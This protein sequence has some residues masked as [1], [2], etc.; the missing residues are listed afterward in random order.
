VRALRLGLPRAS[1]NGAADGPEIQPADLSAAPTPSYSSAYAAVAIPAD[2]ES[3]N[4][5]FWYRPAAQSLTGGDLQLVLLLDPF[6]FAIRETL[7]RRLEQADRWLPATHDLTRYRGQSLLLYFSVYNDNIVSGPA[8]W[9][10]VDDVS[11]LACTGPTPAP[12]RRALWL[13]LMRR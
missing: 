6:T 4:L 9:M 10:F 11:L 2:A 8:A 12:P 3:A 13:P 5:S 1:E 7:H